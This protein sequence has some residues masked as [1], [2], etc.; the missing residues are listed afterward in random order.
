MSRIR[1]LRLRG[2]FLD[3]TVTRTRIGNSLRMTVTDKV[4]G[5]TR[6]L[7]VPK[8]HQGRVSEWVENWRLLKAALRELSELQR[9]EFRREI[10]L[11]AGGG[12]GGRRPR[13]TKA[14]ARIR[15]DQ[16]GGRVAHGGRTPRGDPLPARGQAARPRRNRALSRFLHGQAVLRRQREDRLR[17]DG[18]QGAGEEGQEEI[19]ASRHL[20]G[21]RRALRLPARDANLR[22]LRLE[23][24]PHVQE[25]PHPVGVRG[26]VAQAEPG[27]GIEG[28]GGRS[29]TRQGSASTFPPPNPAPTAGVRFRIRL[30]TGT[31]RATSS[32]RTPSRPTCGGVGRGS[33]TAGAAGGPCAR[34]STA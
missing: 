32:C 31:R 25:G 2:R 4:N 33:G 27:A 12:G 34:G 3:G 11:P 21:G 24:R 9:S 19:S 5:K 15:R 22:G 6:T 17:T 29:S 30:S 26:F 18:L 8:E 20:R 7:F 16:A 23:V 10:G 28:T 14:P 13:R 1:T